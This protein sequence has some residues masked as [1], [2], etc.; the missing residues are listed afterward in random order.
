MANREQVFPDRGTK[1]DLERV[2]RKGSFS[3]Y[4]GFAKRQGL[5]LAGNFPKAFT[6][7]NS[8]LLVA[9]VL[10][11]A[12]FGRNL[13]DIIFVS[14]MAMAASF[15]TI[16]KRTIRVPSAVELVTLG[17]VVTG[18]AYGPMVGALFGVVTTIASEI[19]SSGIDVNTLFYA[20]ARGLAGGLAQLMVVSFGWGIV[21]AGMAALVIFHV[22]SDFIYVVS[23]GV[24]AVPKILYFIVVNTIFNLMV[25]A[26]FGNLLLSFAR[27]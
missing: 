20:I 21:V 2:V 6:I 18:V 14:V 16:Y 27:L 17:T 12:F 10:I 23:G 15:S 3:D 8:L 7:R 1:T 22:V 13:K 4:A 19:I 25:F 24:E 5:Q 9:A 26:F 11:L